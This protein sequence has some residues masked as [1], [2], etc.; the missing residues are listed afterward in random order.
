MFDIMGTDMNTCDVN[1][2]EKTKK[3]MVALAEYIFSGGCSK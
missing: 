1:N 3:K 2:H